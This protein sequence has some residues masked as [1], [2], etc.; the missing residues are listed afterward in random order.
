[1]NN[2][3]WVMC[4]AIC[5]WFSR[6]TK[7]RL[8]ANRITIDPKIII[9]GD[10]CVILFLTRYFMSLN[11]QFRYKQLPTANFAIVTKD[12]LSWFSI[13]LSLQFICDVMRM[14]GTGIVTSYSSIVLARTN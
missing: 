3:F 9:H 12:S 8:L 14:L 11:A 5:Q 6:V 10:E 13:V 1:M 7:S 2:N 4:E